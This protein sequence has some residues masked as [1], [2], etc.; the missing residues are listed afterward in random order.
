MIINK[1]LAT[2]SILLMVLSGYA[3]YVFGQTWERIVWAV[4]VAFAV[5]AIEGF[6]D[7]IMIEKSISGFVYFLFILSFVLDSLLTLSIRPLIYGGAMAITYWICIVLMRQVMTDSLF[8]VIFWISIV[9][10]VVVVAVSLAG[11]VGTAHYSGIFVN[12]NTFGIFMESM[13]TVLISYYAHKAIENRALRIYDYFLIIAC[14]ILI[15]VS[16]CRIA[17]GTMLVQLGL[18]LI[19]ALSKRQFDQKQVWITAATILALIVV[20]LIVS[21][22]FSLLT[23]IQD[24]FVSKFKMSSDQGDITDG[25]M[26]MWKA[27]IEKSG[28][29]GDGNKA[30]VNSR[31]LEA[32]NTYLGLANQ[33]GKINA[34]LFLIFVVINGIETLIAALR[35]DAGKWRF[36]PLMSAVGFA[37]V[38]MTENFLMTMPMLMFFFSIP[39]CKYYGAKK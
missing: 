21:G 13:F 7:E 11:G 6:T 18:F 20:L 26:V 38:S 10:T 36:L 27:I 29:I 30:Y 34:V 8:D 4:A 37:M 28:L 12:P 9:W 14:A 1:K 33:Y 19:L 39:L 31:G 2:I 32:H 15:I 5:F 22:H 17:I 25:R 24:S 23:I 16:S 35:S 3:Y